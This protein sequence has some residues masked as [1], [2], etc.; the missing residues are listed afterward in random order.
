MNNSERFQEINKRMD[1]LKSF[2]PFFK[3][4]TTSS[5]QKSEYDVPYL[6]LDILTLLIEKG[7]LLGRAVPMDTIEHHITCTM[8]EMY[9]ERDFDCHAVTRNML[10][11]LETDTQ[12]MLYRFNYEDPIRKSPVDHYI[13]FVEFDVKEKS[14]RITDE[15]LD[16]MISIKELPEESKISVTLILFK[17][18]IESGSFRNALS[19]IRDLNLEVQRKKQRKQDLLDKLMYGDPDILEGFEKY[20]QEVIAQLE[21]ENELFTQVRT[22][23]K[24]LSEKRETIIENPNMLGKAE[25]FAVITEISK[26]LEYGYTLHNSL[27]KDYTDFPGE[28][29][30]ISQIRLDSLFERRYQFQEALQ[31]HI[32]DNLSN[33][34][35]VMEIHPML[36]PTFQKQFSLFKIY[37]PQVMPGNK[38]EVSETRSKERFADEKSIDEI[39]EERQTENFTAYAQCLLKAL[40]EH[41]SLELVDYLHEIDQILGRPGIENLDL[42]P[43]LI[44]LNS[45]TEILLQTNGSGRAMI[46][47]PYETIFDLIHLQEGKE[48]RDT[49]ERALN[50]ACDT[51]N[52]HF[53][54]LRV[55]ANPQERI[56]IG[57]LIG[58]YIS[59]MKFIGE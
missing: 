34:V 10:N 49:I 37:E 17:K 54:R 52:V 9:P 43:F 6:C 5:V 29:E 23:L 42:I 1:Y 15:G 12:G 40:N 53:N 33:E 22:T 14:Y 55:I 35:H 16:F 11:L 51:T 47:D 20:T 38:E 21:Q 8:K 24:D 39:V 48:G 58:V 36:R 56:P 46:Q 2:Y 30:R 7:R 19:T 41:E 28:Y 25:D 32:R 59:N 50:T 31:N 57:D 27:L 18:Q 45:G 13:H 3:I 26:E 44:E 4:Y